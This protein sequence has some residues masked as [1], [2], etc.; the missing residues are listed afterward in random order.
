[1]LRRDLA[2]VIGV[3]LLQFGRCILL[4]CALLPSRAPPPA[5]HQVINERSIQ[6]TSHDPP[7]IREVKPLLSRSCPPLL[8]ISVRLF[9][10]LLESP[11]SRQLWAC[12]TT[13]SAGD[14]STRCL[15]VRKPRSGRDEFREPFLRVCF[16]Q[17]RNGNPEPSRRYTA[18]RC[19]DYLRAAVPLI[20]G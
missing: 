7:Q 6:P 14:S 19:R 3:S 4:L 9:P 15:R 2:L 8:W 5:D 17:A 1:M 11:P 20:T 13:V 16:S 18:G 10:S 12:S